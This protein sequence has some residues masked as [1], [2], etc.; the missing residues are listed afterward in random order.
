MFD[1][2]KSHAKVVDVLRVESSL[3]DG[4]AS[5]IDFCAEHE[6]WRGWNALRKLEFSTDRSR[7]SRWLKGLLTK[8]PPPKPI[9]A[10]W[11]G[12]FNPIVDGKTTC[13]IYVAGA[14]AFDPEDDTF[15][16]A[17]DP[18]YF[19]DGRY[20]QS[21]VLGEI[22]QSVAKKAGGAS[23][24]EY[25]LCLGYV[26]LVVKHL[27]IKFGPETWLGAA[28]SRALAVGFDSGDGVLLGS[29]TKDGWKPNNT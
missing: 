14:S 29:V 25:V 21:Q 26:G 2:S 22:Y 13:G 4:M 27:A 1:I 23:Y 7:L 10:Y 28:R 11:F 3:D 18:A 17:C 16:W 6:K 5:L 20:A 15:E 19:P 12:L 8:A 9:K 24:G